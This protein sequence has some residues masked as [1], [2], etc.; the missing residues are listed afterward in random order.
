MGIPS[1]F[2]Y[3]VK[4]YPHILSK[5]K[6]NAKAVDN[7]YL[8]CNSIIYDVFHKLSASAVGATMSEDE[9]A[10]QIIRGTIAKIQEY[11]LAVHP[12]KTT[13][14]A[15]DG[16]A[17]VAKIEQQRTRRYKSWYQTEVSKHI[18][19]DKNKKNTWSTLSI[20]PG[21]RFMSELNRQIT[22]AFKRKTEVIVSDSSDPGEGEHKLFDYIR[23][24]PQKH[25]KETTVIYGLDA[26]L[27]VLSICHLQY[28]PNL[29]LLR[30]SPHF[31]M[32]NLEPDTNYLLNI[33][34]LNAK[35]DINS[36]D[37]IILTFMLGNDF[38]PHFPAANIRTGGMDKLMIAYRSLF[39]GYDNNKSNLAG[40]DGSINWYN[41]RLLIATLAGKEEEFLREEHKLRNRREYTYPIHSADDKFKKFE[42]TPTF[43]R[44]L[45][46][47]I[48]P[49]T[50]GW[51]K[52]YYENLFPC[53]DGVV[54]NVCKNWCEGI[55]WNFYYY[56]RGCLDWRWTYRYYYPPL[57]SDLNTFLLDKTGNN[58]TTIVSFMKMYSNQQT[59]MATITR[60]NKPVS[61]LV[62]L[63]CVLPYAGLVHLPPELRKKLIEERPEWY[64]T[65]CPFLWAYCRYFWESHVVMEHIDISVMEK[66]V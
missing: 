62:Q 26:D 34:E 9:T 40:S 39:L 25:E 10:Q 53:F 46:K 66:I 43:E 47:H 1:Y 37:Y 56:T 29:F 20:T 15:F 23:Q 22:D 64:K 19:G 30:E 17:P 18:Y 65:D 32:D 45:E 21:T 14:I 2:S 31:H 7:L 13:Y 63:C 42:A 41:M 24:N 4:N 48:D 3:I 33:S 5:F 8:D 11:I 60:T 38:L 54:S 44:D 52:R 58:A 55:E 57:F 59:M 35:I 6:P 36:H 50:G 27:I 28:A 12:R 49:F 16:V 51:Q 61:S